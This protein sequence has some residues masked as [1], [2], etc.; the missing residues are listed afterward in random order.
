LVGVSSVFDEQRGGVVVEPLTDVGNDCGCESSNG[1]SGGHVIEAGSD[2]EI[3]E[4]LS[5]TPSTT[6]TE[7]SHPTLSGKGHRG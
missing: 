7:R 4:M 3:G 2:E 6:S 1:F 5:E